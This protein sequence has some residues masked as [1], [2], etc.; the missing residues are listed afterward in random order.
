MDILESFYETLSRTTAGSYRAIWKVWRAWSTQ[1][2][3]EILNPTLKEAYGFFAEIKNRIGSD[4]KPLAHKTR[5]NY[6]MALSAIYGFL[7]KCDVAKS[8]PWV[9]LRASLPSLVGAQKKQFRMLSAEE[10]IAMLSAPQGSSKRVIRDRAMLSILFASGVRLSELHQLNIGDFKVSPE[11]V[12]YLLLR[13]TKNGDTAYQSIP[14]WCA[15]RVSELV[16]AR[17]QEGATNDDP[18]FPQYKNSGL[19]GGRC[20]R[21]AIQKIFKKYARLCGIEGVSPHC[22]RAT[23]TTHL[24]M[25]GFS[26]REVAFATRHKS[27]RMVQVYD[28]RTLSIANNVALKLKYK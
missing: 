23:F 21:R 10:V 17:Y 1:N 14:E 27:R 11:G 24:L 25:Q 5:I 13:Q 7:K 9:E 19:P 12:I 3:T 20:S 16:K 26:E 4:G 6:L 8:N 28:K 15:E 22:A 18:L 2:N